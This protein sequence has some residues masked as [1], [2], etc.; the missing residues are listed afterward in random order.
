MSSIYSSAQEIAK[1]I[2]QGE[3][4]SVE[5]VQ[6]HLDQIKQHNET[7]HSVAILTEDEALAAAEQRDQEAREGNFRGPLHGVPMTIKEQFWL[8]GTKSTINSDRYEDW[9]APE[10]AVVVDRL[11][12]AGAVIMG[13]TNVPKDLLDYQVWGDFYPEGKNPYDTAYSPGGSSG[14]AAAALAS[15]MVPLELGGD[16]GGSIRIPAYFC[17]IYGLKPTE[18]TIPWHGHIPKAD[19]ERGF[20]FHMAQGGPMARNVDDMEMMWRVILGPHHSDRSTPRI[21]WK[22]SSGKALSDYK[23]AWVD[24]WP[25]YTPSDEIRTVIRELIE[26]VSD[27]GAETETVPPKEG[28]HHRSLAVWMRLAHI[29]LA[30][31]VPWYMK[32]LMKMQLKS[33]FYYGMEKFTKELKQGF[34]SSFINYSEA[35]GDRAEIVSEWEQYFEEYDLL[36]CPMSFGPTYERREIGT[37]ITYEGKTMKYLD[38]NWPYVA[39]F[40]AS[41]HPCM[42]IPLGLND[43]GLPVGVQVVGPYWSEPDMLQFAGLVAEQTTGFV[44]PEG[45]A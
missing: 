19:S 44:R 40:N 33:S 6:E 32:P 36:I 9:V 41:G 3:T 39:C 45:Y 11:K 35:M 21:D 27:N 5:V 2:R 16:F 13:K 42:N 29:I 30:Q 24:R 12:Q 20:V 14:G 28:L 37:E 10:D 22:D 15:G 18:D 26:E 23:I 4:T 34:K 43:R 17:G 1:Q 31:D 38:Y 7:L 25:D 8:E